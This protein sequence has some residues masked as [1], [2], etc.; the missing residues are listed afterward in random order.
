LNR[1]IRYSFSLKE[2]SMQMFRSS[3]PDRA[4]IGLRIKRSGLVL[5]FGL[6]AVASA[7]T[8][9]DM[10]PATAWLGDIPPVPKELSATK[11]ACPEIWAKGEEIRA[12]YDLESDAF[13]A[14]FDDAEEMSEQQAMAMLMQGGGVQEIQQFAQAQLQMGDEM[15]NEVPALMKRKELAEK[16]L[17]ELV[18][19]MDDDIRRCRAG[20]S[21][22]GHHGEG[23]TAAEIACWDQ[24]GQKAR[25]CWLDAANRYLQAAQAPLRD[26]KADLHKYLDTRERYLLGQEAAHQNEYL[27]AQWKRQRIELLEQAAEY[28]NFLAGVCGVAEQ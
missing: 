14:Q 27:R 24:R 19:E 2:L 3:S 13:D 25:Q 4:G 11:K 16:R 6:L 7:A 18:R 28:A 17:A 9:D 21:D 15:T 23:M 12:A 22:C 1:G 8:A 20:L 5:A 10:R 26:W